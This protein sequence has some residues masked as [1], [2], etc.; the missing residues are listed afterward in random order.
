MSTKTQR[1]EMQLVHMMKKFCTLWIEMDR[2][3]LHIVHKHG[4]TPIAALGS[5]MRECFIAIARHGGI[6]LP[7][8][9]A[10]KNLHT[11]EQIKLLI[12]KIGTNQAGLAI[13]LK[14]T[15]SML[16]RVINGKARSHRIEAGIEE[17]IG[18]KVFPPRGKPGP[19]K[20]TWNG[21]AQA[22]AA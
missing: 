3:S 14:T 5:H 9:T 7:D 19:V 16:G 11:P 21:K 13:Y 17:A 15:P 8:T 20:T 4:E 12:A 22:V 10:S 2:L 18:V 1:Q 6:Q